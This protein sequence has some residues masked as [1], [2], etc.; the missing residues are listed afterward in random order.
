M[1]SKGTF[2]YFL[3]ILTFALAFAY[4]WKGRGR[5]PCLLVGKRIGSHKAHP[6]FPYLDKSAPQKQLSRVNSSF[7]LPQLFNVRSSSCHE[8]S[9]E[10]GKN[11]V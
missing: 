6:T 7:S 3:F 8:L 9:S 5:F 4:Q 1:I 11:E 10:K 2:F